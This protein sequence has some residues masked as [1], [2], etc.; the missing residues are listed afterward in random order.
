EG[1][2]GF[3]NTGYQKYSIQGVRNMSDKPLEE[4]SQAE[5]A[6]YAIDVFRRIILHYGIWFSEV[7]HQLGLEEAIR[8]EK[9]VFAWFWPMAVNRLGRTLGFETEDGLPLPLL[10][11]EK[12]KLIRLTKAMSTVWMLSDG[13]WF[14]TVENNHDIFTSKRCNDTC[15]TRYSPV[16]AAMAKSFLQLPEQSGLDGLEQAL[17]FQFSAHINERTVERSGDGLVLRTV[18]CL[19]Q[20][21]RR[22][23]RLPDY[24]CKS[25]G[26][27]EFKAFAGTID[28]R[29]GVECISCPPDEHPETWLCAWRFYIGEV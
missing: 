2:A 15:W 17:R 19:V 8:I 3:G 24:P 20:E 5:L 13:V 29:I 26:M 1:T 21:S 6:H 28:S 22:R 12:E 25:A 4:L 16:E 9:E 14:R 27:A 7:T 23:N 10:N 11:M 18:K